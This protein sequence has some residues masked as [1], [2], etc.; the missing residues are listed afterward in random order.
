MSIKI[1]ILLI[2][3]IF[4]VIEVLIYFKLQKPQNEAN[5]SFTEPL[6]IVKEQKNM[7]AEKQINLETEKQENIETEKQEN[8]EIKEQKSEEELNFPEDFELP[9]TFV[10]QAPMADWDLPYQEACEEASMIMVAKYFKQQNLTPEIMDDE[11]KKIVKWQQDYFGYYQH[12][13]A[14][15]VVET[16]E[17][18]FNLSAELDFNINVE[19]IK[20]Q[21]Y[22]GKLIIIPSSGRD[23]SN[24]YFSG[25]GPIYHMLVIRGW[26]E[27]EFITND[28][29]TRR[30]AGFKYQY[31]NLISSVHNVLSGGDG[32]L[33]VE[34]IKQGQPVMI[35][36]GL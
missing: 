33:K 20:Q 10:S 34:E 18:Y 13:T 11:I 4:L 12:T 36:V 2:L 30:G 6:E 9:V 8:I 23:L 26:D 35:V 5:F 28:P 27:D 14:Q 16:L 25:E 7:R 32:D 19:N 17:K 1:K 21:L 3:A 15:E 31:Q 29:G 24:P 22:Q